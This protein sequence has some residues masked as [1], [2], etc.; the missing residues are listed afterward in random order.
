MISGDQPEHDPDCFRC[1]YLNLAF[2]IVLDY[3]L[4]AARSE[5]VLG[6]G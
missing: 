1:E 2:L 3:N 6:N 5:G 4:C